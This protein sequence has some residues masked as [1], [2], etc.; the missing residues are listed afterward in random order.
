MYNTNYCTIDKRLNILKF[1]VLLVILF[2]YQKK[3]ASVDHGAPGPRGPGSVYAREIPI[4]NFA[5]SYNPRL[6]KV[7]FKNSFS[8]LMMSLL[9]WYLILP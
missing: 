7:V 5:V 6:V 3:P 4:L 1:K 9:F 2:D 8:L